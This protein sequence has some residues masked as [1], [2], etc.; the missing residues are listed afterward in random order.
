MKISNQGFA[1]RV[2]NRFRKWID[3]AIGGTHDNFFNYL[4]VKKGMTA[5]WLL[6]LFFSGIKDNQEQLAVIRDIPENATIVYLN[7]FKSKFDFLFYHTRYPANHLPTPEIGLG[8]RFFIL[9][10][11]KRTLRVLISAADA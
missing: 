6:K 10:P 4:P 1:S 9:Q 8:Y 3:R 2:K 5:T 11:V 7:K